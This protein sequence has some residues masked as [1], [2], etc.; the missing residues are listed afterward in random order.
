[1]NEITSLITSSIQ[2][3]A[4]DKEEFKVENAVD[5]VKSQLKQWEKNDKSTGLTKEIRKAAVDYLLSHDDLI[6]DAVSVISKTDVDTNEFAMDIER[7]LSK[8]KILLNKQI[9]MLSGFDSEIE[10]IK[11][12]INDSIKSGAGKIKDSMNNALDKLGSDKESDGTTPTSG[13]ASFFSFNYRDYLK[14]LL[15]IKFMSNGETTLLRMADVIQV[16]M[17]K[18]SGNTS[19]RLKNSACYI[20]LD[21]KTYVKPLF[22]AVPLIADTASVSTDGGNGKRTFCFEYHYKK[23][24]GY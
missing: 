7:E 13:S 19:Y 11:G 9:P 3:S 6:T 12:Q 1:M 22:L 20:T 23:T 5:Y 15:L 17:V 16:N 8:I 24:K 18:V 14:L 2:N 4:N 10:K 21:C